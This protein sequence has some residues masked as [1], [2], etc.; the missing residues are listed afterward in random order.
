VWNFSSGEGRYGFQEG[1]Y[2]LQEGGYGFF[3]IC[4]V[5]FIS[6]WMRSISHQSLSPYRSPIWNK[7]VI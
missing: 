6:D 7:H 2:G 3:H 5:D 4:L 1:R